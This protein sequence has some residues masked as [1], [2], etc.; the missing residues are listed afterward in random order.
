MLA[1]LVAGSLLGAAGCRDAMPHSFTWIASGDQIP[2]H[3]KPPEGGYYSNWD[4]YA[5]SLEVTPV[6]SVNPVRT[7]HVL[8]A[9]VRDKDGKPLPNRRVEWILA[10]GDNAVGEIVEVDESGFRASRGYKVDNLYAVSHTNNSKHVLD[11]GNDDPSDDIHLEKGQTWCVITSPMEG[12]THVTV[13]CPGIYDWSK[14]KVFV[15]KH[16]YDVTWQFPPPATNP[17]GTVHEFVTTVTK[18]S[19]GTYIPNHAVTYKILDGPAAVLEPGGAQAATV[20]TDAQGQAKVKIRQVKPAE[21]T[22]NLSLELVRPE[23]PQCCEPAV[24]IATGKTSKTWIGPKITI[25]KTCTGSAQVGD[26]V[27]Y[28]I[29]VTNPSQVEATNVTVSDTIPDGITYVSSTPAATASGNALT[30]SLGSLKAQGRSSISVKAKAARVGKFENCAEVRAD[31]GL[32]AKDCCSTVVTSPKLA[33]EKKCPA[34]VTVCDNIEYVITVRNAGDGP[35]K[36]VKINDPL[37]AG[38]AT[39]DGKNA[40]TASVGDLGPGQSKEI[41]FTVKASKPGRY[42]NKVTATAD[43]NLTAEANCS[44]VVKQPALEVTKTGPKERF[45]GRDATYEITVKNTGDAPARDTVLTDPLPSGLQFVSASDGGANQG[46]TVTW[47][48][49]VLDPGASKKV[50][51]TVKALTP[52][53]AKNVA[54]ATAYCAEGQATM[55]MSVE[56]IPAVLLEVIDLEDPDEVGTTTTYL[57]TV[58]NQGSADATNVKIIAEVQPEAVYDSSSGATPGTAAARTVTFAPLAKIAPKAKAEW[59]VVVKSTKAGD[60]RFKVS[61]TTDQIA[62]Q[63]AVQETESTRFYE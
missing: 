38:L 16:W 21:G 44:T 52:G 15:T 32:N 36:N 2:T 25:D 22:N 31:H 14:H 13:Y 55:D 60:T 23:N 40:Y 54:R 50:T 5:V 20:M 51:L 57:I 59:R 30:W 47:R 43:G 17:I 27:S 35:A 19:D 9:T 3:P 10:R 48:L 26:D 56:G 7:Q 8:I 1:A 41:R 12:D 18:A 37:P 42:D 34:E 11:R 39:S 29:E 6:E 46:G 28:T 4:P 62:S 24:K 53:T 61:M 49:G 45:I 33:I 58:T 63:G